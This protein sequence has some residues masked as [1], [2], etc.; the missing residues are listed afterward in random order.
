MFPAQ[1]DS[2]ML[3]RCPIAASDIVQPVR[4]DIRQ[5]TR[6]LTAMSGLAFVGIALHRFAEIARRIDTRFPIRQG[7][8]SSQILSSYIGL[9]VEGKSDFEA[10]E[11]KRG[12]RF[13]SDSLGLAGA[14]S[15]ATLRQRMDALG[16]VASEAVDGL[17]VPL[18][19][20]GRA[21]FSP[22]SSGHIP[23]DIDVFCLDNSD[24]RKE[25]V[26]R[27]YAG[28]DGYAP[29][30]AYLGAR[31]GYCLA[32]ELRDGVQHSAK[33]TEYTLERVIARAL[34]L[35]T[36]RLLLRWDSGFDSERLF[37][38]AFEQGSGRVDVL[39]KWNPRS[40]DVEG[41]A[42]AKRKDETTVWLSPREGK[43]I[44]TWET[45]GRTI[46]LA[47]GSTV[48]LRRVLRLTERTIKAD[49]TLLLLP[50]V[51]IDGWETT[52]TDSI[53]TVIAL[54]ADHATHEQF[55]SEFKTDLDLE[56]LPSGKFDTN[57]LVLS[58]A[59]VA[60][61]VLRLIGQQSLLKKD[62]P[63]RHPAKRRRLKTV[64]QE[65]LR[66]AAQLTEHARR[67]ALNFGRHCPAFQVWR[68]LYVEWT[69]PGWPIP[70]A[71]DTA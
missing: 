25:G 3:P 46:T 7:L 65:M 27:T 52:L 53:E 45:T 6:D 20:R 59:A 11:G 1:L 8:P 21:Q 17:L 66:V 57:I 60:Y 64:M 63:L 69:T 42:A 55:H 61:N 18:L 71:P 67:V 35:T 16:A 19:K 14:P 51:V 38:T 23:V 10:I 9:L 31:E 12:D 29:V 26:G 13:F 50:E 5:S 43:R 68:E 36:E 34:A 62:A 4:F 2:I 32:L 48:Q 44:T 58:L 49:G 24:S 33:E 41:C 39:G 28:Y 40:F 30:A 47:D 70:P 15:A 37:A 56:R 54:Y 22:V